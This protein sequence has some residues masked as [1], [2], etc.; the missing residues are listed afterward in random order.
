MVAAAATYVNKT[1]FWIFEMHWKQFYSHIMD[2]PN[3]LK[4]RKIRKKTGIF[5]VRDLFKSQIEV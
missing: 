3:N 2:Y 4:M 5:V 1:Y